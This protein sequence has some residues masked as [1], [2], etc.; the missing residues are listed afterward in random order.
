MSVVSAL[1]DG[2]Q[3]VLNAPA[4]I[5][6]VWA[7]F[8]LVPSPV[9]IARID[10]YVALIDA[11][12]MD[13]VPALVSLLWSNL[14]FLSHAVLFTFLLGGAM[15]RLARNRATATFGFFGACGMFVFRFARLG[16]I[17]VPLYTGLFLWLAPRL[18]GDQAASVIVLGIL[19]I[20]GHVLFDYAKVRMVVEDR[21]SAI[22]ALVASTRFIRRNPG[23]AITLAVINGSIAAA[24]WWL[25]ATFTVGLSAALYAYLLAR[26]LLKLIFAASHIA[27]FQS[28]LAHA[29]YTARAPATWP[30]SPAAE[31]VRP[32]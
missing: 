13:A 9:A 14:A 10:S 32:Y 16:L 17:A 31:A 11:S 12:A 2:C 19:V 25:A 18:P 26:A 27:L 3:R 1:A 7:V 28:R 29:G 30:E 15:D 8:V 20:L 21:R 5:I 4:L 23:A 24:T 6:G 22:G